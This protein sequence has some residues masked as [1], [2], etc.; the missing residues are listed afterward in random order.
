M[1]EHEPT[2]GIDDVM[3]LDARSDDF[4]ADTVQAYEALSQRVKALEDL[5]A[6]LVKGQG[7]TADTLTSVTEAMQA[8]TERILGHA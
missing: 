5:V 7:L 8:V 3:V 2:G 1:S 6:S 4:T